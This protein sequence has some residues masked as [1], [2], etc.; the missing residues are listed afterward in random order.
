MLIAGRGHAMPAQCDTTEGCAADSPNSSCDERVFMWK[1]RLRHYGSCCQRAEFAG[2]TPVETKPG[3]T[4][5]CCILC[6][7]GKLTRCAHGT[8]RGLTHTTMLRI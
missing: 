1:Q 4:I 6:F 3:D 8:V 5:V 7:F 2:R